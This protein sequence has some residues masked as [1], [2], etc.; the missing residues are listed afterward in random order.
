MYAFEGFLGKTTV[1]HYIPLYS[2]NMLC[3]VPTCGRVALPQSTTSL[4]EE[5]IDQTNFPTLH[6]VAN[7]TFLQYIL[8]GGGYLIRRIIFYAYML[9]LLLFKLFIFGLNIKLYSI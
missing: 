1:G 3:V 6:C 4:L 8:G 7:V 9:L 5:I 2:F